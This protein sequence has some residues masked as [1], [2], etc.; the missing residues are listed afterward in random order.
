MKFKVGD[1]VVGNGKAIVYGITR[2]GWKGV[3]TKVISDR[4]IRVCADPNKP[5]S[6]AEFEVLADCFDLVKSSN[7]SKIVITTDG[8]TT[9][10]RLYEGKSVIK[11]A[12]AKCSA[13]DEFDFKTGAALAVD[14][15]LDREVKAEKPEP[16]LFPLEDIKAGY[17]L[18][19]CEP[20]E[21]Y[22][23]TVLPNA[24]GELGCCNGKD[25]WWSL[26]QFGA[27]LNYLGSRIDAVYGGARNGRLL[28]N[29]PDNRELL[30]SRD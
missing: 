30:W 12:E 11:S 8:T 2:E 26:T 24:R 5:L 3:V 15:L 7:R 23:M 16:K 29:S 20:T 4:Y 14:R 10:A 28:A 25:Q 17:L 13:D 18:K 21:E 6:N 22:Y 27:E 9:T 19:V 1:H